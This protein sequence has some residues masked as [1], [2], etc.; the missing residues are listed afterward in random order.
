M[1][2]LTTHGAAGVR[3]L[4][5]GSVA[6]KVIRAAAKPVLVLRPAFHPPMQEGI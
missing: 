2:G 4:L 6:E 3:R 5:L 1:V